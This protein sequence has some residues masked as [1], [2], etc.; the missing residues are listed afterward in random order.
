MILSSFKYYLCAQS[1]LTLCDPIDCSPPSS[2][3]HGILQARILEWVA[4]PFSRVSSQPTDWTQVSCIAGRF[5]TIWATRKAHLCANGTQIMAHIKNS[6][7]LQSP[8]SRCLLHHSLGFPIGISKITEAKQNYS[9]FPYVC[10]LLSH[11]FSNTVSGLT[12]YP[13][14][15]AQNWK[16]SLEFF[17]TIT[18]LIPNPSVSP[19]VLLSKLHVNF[20]NSQHVHDY[21]WSKLAWLV[22][23]SHSV[24]SDSLQRHKPQHT[25]PPCPS[26]TPGVY[27]NP[28]TVSQ[29]CRP[30]ISSSVFPFSSCF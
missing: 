27:P 30:T 1:C 20:T 15:Q 7:E 14:L 4:I 17:L 12:I 16:V 22:Q 10:F 11:V 21:N 2:S 5:F 25:R 24:V 13:P 6:P 9:F 8:R 29:W 23:F 26:P 3:V 18:K 28:C 19:T